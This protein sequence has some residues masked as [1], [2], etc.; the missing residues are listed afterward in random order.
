MDR[1]LETMFDREQITM[2]ELSEKT[3]MSEAIIY[4]RLERYEQLG[5]VK[6]VVEYVEGG[7]SGTCGS[8]KGCGTH[9]PK[10]K[11]SVYWIRGEKLR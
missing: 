3:N 9:R 11:P 4:A 8:C 7:C 1:L 2:G 10:F 6:K 5:Y